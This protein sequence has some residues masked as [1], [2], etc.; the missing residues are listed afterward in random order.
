MPFAQM[1]R[2]RVQELGAVAMNSSVD[3]DEIEVLTQNVEYLKSTLSLDMLEV[4]S[5]DD[6]SVNEKTREEVRPGCP[7]IS[8]IVRPSIKVQFNNPIPRSGLFTQYDIQVADGDTTTMLREK[9]AKTIGLAAKEPLQLWRYIDP[10]LGPR[11]L[12]IFDDFK[13]GK[14]LMEDGTLSISAKDD[15]VYLTGSDGTKMP[16]GIDLIYVVI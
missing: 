4:K 16:I 10:V 2:E 11:K 1:I 3:F 14:T 7:F 13:A 8:Y 12:P 5:T 9:L 6:P 15:M